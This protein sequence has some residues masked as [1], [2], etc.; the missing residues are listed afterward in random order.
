M[1]KLKK[2]AYFCQNCGS[3]QSKWS[4]KCPDCNSWNSLIEENQNIGLSSNGLNNQNLQKASE[5]ELYDIEQEASE[6]AIRVLTNIVEIDRVLGG[7]LVKGSAVL[8]AGDPGIGKSTLLLQIS[9]MLSKKQHKTFYISGEESVSQIHIR[10][11]RLGFEKGLVKVASA[12]NIINIL[13]TAENKKN[14]PE[15]IIIDSIQTMYVEGIPSIAGTISQIRASLSALT[16]FA[17]NHNITLIIISHITKD[18][19]IAGP[20]L[21]E[22]MVDTVLYFEGEKD[23]QYRM[24]RA[25]KNRFGAANEIGVFEMSDCGLLEVS[26]PS[27]LFLSNRDA[28]I[29][30]VATFATME[31]SRVLLAEVQ[32]LISPS[33]MPSPRR[34]VVGWDGNR[35]ALIIAVLNSRFGLNLSDKE[36]YLNIASG[37]KV[38]EPAADLSAICALI[39]TAK[40]ISIP[41]KTVIIGEVALTGEIRMTSSME[42]RI[43]ESIKLGFNNFILPSAVKEIRNFAIISEDINLF[44]V[45]NVVDLHKF[46]NK[47]K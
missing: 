20:K 43:K 47:I 32:T 30:G 19:Q 21:L 45:D 9:F 34:A 42:S 12:S 28:P 46:F 36:V 11:K 38:Q 29:S 4:G 26:N 13:K 2:T 6:N 41:L 31:G 1:S 44:C 22:H 3:V 39:S 27:K 25:I 14:T 37:L 10:A 17:K 5:I 8:I 18:G 40:N 33:Y 23:S 7:G 15:F 24:V 16:I 35:L